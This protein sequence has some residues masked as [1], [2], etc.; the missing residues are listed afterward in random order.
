MFERLDNVCTVFVIHEYVT[1][2]LLYSR[3]VKNDFPRGGPTCNG[4]LESKEL[5]G[6]VYLEI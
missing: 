4:M 3:G 1:F 6:K 2:W 5:T